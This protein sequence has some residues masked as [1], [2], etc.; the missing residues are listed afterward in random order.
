[1]NN[2]KSKSKPSDSEQRGG[3]RPHWMT[4]TLECD[5]PEDSAHEN[6]NYFNKCVEC[7]A[8]FIGHKLRH[9]CRKCHYEAMTPKESDTHNANVAKA[10]QDFRTNKPI[11][12]MITYEVQ[13][14]NNKKN[15][16]QSTDFE[17]CCK[18]INSFFIKAKNQTW[19]RFETIVSFNIKSPKPTKPYKPS[20]PNKP[21]DFE[22]I[23]E[24]R[25]E[26]YSYL[27][28]FDIIKHCQTKL[29]YP[30]FSINDI[31]D[32][33]IKSDYDSEFTVV[34]ELVDSFQAP[35]PP[36]TEKDLKKY[37]KKLTQYKKKLELYKSKMTEYEKSI[38]EYNCQMDKIKNF[39]TNLNSKNEEA[40]EKALLSELKAKYPNE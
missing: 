22:T 31:Q 15:T 16:F 9:V 4:E 23:K 35:L 21:K 26:L 30:D 40:R 24:L 34:V 7:G 25:F 12:T 28:L 29:K 20:K 5:W 13:L 10:I 1:M 33:I 14:G 38:L 18:K 27:T 36:P 19:A 32:I 8:N 11:N 39:I 2:Q 6:G 3:N 17:D 37:N